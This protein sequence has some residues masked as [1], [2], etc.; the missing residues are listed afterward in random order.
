MNIYGAIIGVM[1]DIGAI[2]KD[3]KNSQQG[4]MY[5]GFDDV[6][7]A[8]QPLLVKHKVFIV[9][10][11]LKQAREERQTKTGGNLIYSVCDIEYTFYAEDGSSIKCTVTGEGMDSGDK[12][13]NK[14][15]AI[16]FKYACFQVFCIP[17][18]E[19]KDPDAETHDVKPKT[20]PKAER[21]ID[22]PVE[23][24]AEIEKIKV[25]LINK[26]QIASVESELQ[27][28]GVKVPH[29]TIE[30]KKYNVT[31]LAALNFEQWKEVMATLESLPDK[32]AQSKLDL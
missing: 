13:T 8:L 9:P 10:N 3:K 23:A 28:T 1:G 21:Q 29:I 6:M 4:F 15:M 31:S 20:A 11:I 17:T 5:R 18:E 24:E 19:M 14:A 27:R 25:G 7:N 22:T 26:V 32:P 30:G 16:A 2:G 12:A